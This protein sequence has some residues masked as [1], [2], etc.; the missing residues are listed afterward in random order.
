MLI[1]Q[2]KIPFKQPF[3]ASERGK[4]MEK[5]QRSQDMAVYLNLPA[6]NV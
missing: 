4:A 3:P 1:L 2:H 6:G 5:L